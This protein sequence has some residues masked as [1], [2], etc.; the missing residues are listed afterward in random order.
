MAFAGHYSLFCTI[1]QEVNGLL[2][3]STKFGAHLETVFYSLQH[4]YVERRLFFLWD[5]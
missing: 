4:P 5:F 3:R 1:T 2:V